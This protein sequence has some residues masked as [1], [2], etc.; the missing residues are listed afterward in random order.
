MSESSDFGGEE[1]GLGD[2]PVYV[3]KYEVTIQLLISKPFNSFV[4]ATSAVPTT[5]LSRVERNRQRHRLPSVSRD[6]RALRVVDLRKDQYVQPHPLDVLS[7]ML[8]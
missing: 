1:L 2:I 5:V 4:M 3:S 8:G 7:H 6:D